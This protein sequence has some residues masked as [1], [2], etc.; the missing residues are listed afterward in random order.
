MDFSLNLSRSPCFGWEFGWYMLVLSWYHLSP[1]LIQFLFE[2]AGHRV[3][4]YWIEHRISCQI[5]YTGITLYSQK[6]YWTATR[7]NPSAKISATFWTAQKA[8]LPKIFWFIGC[9][10]VELCNHFWPRVFMKIS[11]RSRR[12]S[13]HG[14]HLA[15][16]VSFQSLSIS[17]VFGVQGPVGTVKRNLFSWS[18][19]WFHHVL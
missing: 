7:N 17:N 16:M 19:N 13:I 9:N 12:T 4:R 8:F 2:R 3:L 5:M 11:R 1:S 10:E 18:P 14:W 15:T 6:T